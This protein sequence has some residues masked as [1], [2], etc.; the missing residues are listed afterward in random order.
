MQ[1]SLNYSG[2]RFLS[3]ENKITQ[4]PG[5]FRLKVISGDALKWY[6]QFS[7]QNEF[8]IKFQICLTHRSLNKNHLQDDRTMFSLLEGLRHCTL[9]SIFVQVF[10]GNGRALSRARSYVTSS[11]LVEMPT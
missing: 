2:T 10:T 3:T 4:F 1:Y 7:F 6:Q 9:R 5:G 8:E 11:P